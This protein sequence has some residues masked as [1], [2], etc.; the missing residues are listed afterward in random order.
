MTQVLLHDLVMICAM[1]L[2]IDNV[3]NVNLSITPKKWKKRHKTL[4]SK[5]SKAPP[6]CTPIDVKHLHSPKLCTES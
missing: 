6:T 2:H 3:N 5:L 1:L 4:S